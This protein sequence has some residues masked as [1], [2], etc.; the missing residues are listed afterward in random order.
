MAFQSALGDWLDGSGWVKSQVLSEIAF[1][2]VAESLLKGK[3]SK[4]RYTNQVT[5][6]ALDEL[7]HMAFEQD[8]THT[9]FD[10]WRNVKE[11][12]SAHFK[13][14]ATTYDMETTLL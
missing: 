7:M 2:G 3:V 6:C 5:L 9:D 12:Q 4:T 14:W 1:S 10:T 13:H 8:N 11:N